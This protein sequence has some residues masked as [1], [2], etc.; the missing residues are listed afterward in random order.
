MN[1]SVATWI[2]VWDTEELT[3][4]TNLYRFDYHPGSFSYDPGI[5]FFYFTVSCYG[6]MG[7]LFSFFPL[8]F[9]SKSLRDDIQTK[10]QQI[11][12]EQTCMNN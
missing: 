9:F 5:F 11:K 7:F 10:P 4:K 2:Y 3:T 8:S 1:Y 12:M 6:F